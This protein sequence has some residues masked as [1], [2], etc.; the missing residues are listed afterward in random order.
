M[1]SRCY[2]KG[3]TKISDHTIDYLGT[4]IKFLAINSAYSHNPDHQ[5]VS[6]VVANEVAGATRQTLGGKTITQDNTNDRAVFDGNDITF[7]LVPAGSTVGGVIGFHDTGA[8]ATSELLVF[9]DVTDTPTNGGD[10]TV[11]FAATGIFYGQI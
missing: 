5:F 1:A 9:N 11:Q 4:T 8:D 7:P 10:I 6:D 3:I 2:N